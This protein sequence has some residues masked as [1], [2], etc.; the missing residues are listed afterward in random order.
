ML[1]KWRDRKS[2]DIIWCLVVHICYCL[3][4]MYDV[5]VTIYKRYLRSTVWKTY[6]Q[7]KVTYIV[8][9]NLPHLAKK[10]WV[11]QSEIGIALRSQSERNKNKR[12]YPRQLTLTWHGCK[13]NQTPTILSCLFSH[14]NH[15]FL[16]KNKF[17][18]HTSTS[19]RTAMQTLSFGRNRKTRKKYIDL[20][21]YIQ[22]Y[23]PNVRRRK[24]RM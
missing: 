18:F 22:C 24:E 17:C 5:R 1:L 15:Y 21:N 2:A 8:K 9:A 13:N 23:E 4:I 7:E 10:M 11:S 14:G 20:T 19:L 3:F 6:F 12:E 16:L